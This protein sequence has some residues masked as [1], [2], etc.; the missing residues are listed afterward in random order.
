MH[1]RRK[2][3]QEVSQDLNPGTPIGDA[4]VPSG[5][6]AP[7]PDAPPPFPF[8]IDTGCCLLFVS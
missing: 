2:L 1:S 8:V 7:V 3:E 6:L 5:V 4:G